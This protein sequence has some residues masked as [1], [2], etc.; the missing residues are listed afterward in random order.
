LLLRV[1][2]TGG[3]M[4]A[5]M[6]LAAMPQFS[7]YGDGRVITQGAQIALYPGPALPA[8]Q[9]T[10]VSPAGISRILEAAGQVGLSGPDRHLP[11]PGNIADAGTVVVTVTT[12]A[13]RHVTR[14]DALFETAG[15]ERDAAR[16]ALRAFTERLSDLRS[17]LGGDV[18]A[19]DEL[20][21]WTSIRLAIR[22]AD[23]AEAPDQQL[24]NFQDWPLPAPLATIGQPFDGGPTRCV[25]LSGADAE[26]LRAPLGGA[27]QLTHWRSGGKTFV[28]VP[29]PLLPDES[30]CPPGLP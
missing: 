12:P 17:W 30:G 19:N 28:I 21:A 20:Y 11:G 16:R 1:E 27:N 5:E 4:P 26:A 23:P 2:T 15:D 8:I 18:A 10:R 6:N 24:V 22:E 25:A 3:F 29:R 14:A 13:G 7:L 9:F